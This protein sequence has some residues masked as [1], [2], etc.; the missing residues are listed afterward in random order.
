MRKVTEWIMSLF[1]SKEAIALVKHEAAKEV[2][3]AMTKYEN[4]KYLEKIKPKK[5]YTK[6]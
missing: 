3:S 5:R 2:K 4:K 6:A 1:F